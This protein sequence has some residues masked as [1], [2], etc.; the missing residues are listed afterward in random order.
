M[1]LGF[2]IA[3]LLEVLI[4]PSEITAWLGTDSSMRGILIGWL[5]GLVIPGGPYPLFPIAAKLWNTGAAPGV[6]IALITAKSLV[7][8]IRMLTHEAPLPG[9]P[10]PVVYRLSSFLQ[11]WEWWDSRSSIYS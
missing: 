2:I 5:A 9:W 8:P 6:L 11:L 1:L 4:S 7:S 10:L 3:G